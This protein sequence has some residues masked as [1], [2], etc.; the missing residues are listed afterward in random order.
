MKRLMLVLVVALLGL[1]PLQSQDKLSLGDVEKWID[2]VKAGIRTDDQAVTFISQHGVDFES[3]ANNLYDLKNRGATE[4]MLDAIRR[5]A[6][7]PPPPPAPIVTPTGS[8]TV[9]CQPAECDIHVNG[10]GFA[11]LNGEAT[12]SKLKL[13]D[14]LVDFEKD[15]YVA[16]QKSVKIVVEPAAALSVTLDPTEATKAA[17]GQRIAKAILHALNVENDTSRLRNLTAS[18]SLKS[19]GSKETDWDFDLVGSA[20]AQ[21]EMR[22]KSSTGGMNFLCI[23]EKCESRHGLHL[24]LIGKKLPPAVEQELESNLRVFAEHNLAALM[25]R[26]KEPSVA[27]SSITLAGAPEQRMRAETSDLAYEVTTGADF[28]PTVVNYESKAGVGGGLKITFA[29]YGELSGSHYPKRTTIRLDKDGHGVEVR[30]DK[31]A[32]SAKK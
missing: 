30:L 2:A 25:D 11:T 28:L 26:L 17:N 20:P 16:Q 23:G 13:G 1:V 5:V 18:G 21:M 9:H 31:I 8:L 22:V 3:N 32:P 14:A 24:P 27:F 10:Q 6:P 15:G 29:D 4:K 7:V 12:I 19:F